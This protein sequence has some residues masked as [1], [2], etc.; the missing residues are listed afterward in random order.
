MCTSAVVGREIGQ[1]VTLQHSVLRRK[2]VSSVRFFVVLSS[3]LCT[4]SMVQC[5]QHPHG[6][7]KSPYL[8]RILGGMF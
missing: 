7:T 1:E 8:I 3:C 5:D 4:E 2:Y 6:C